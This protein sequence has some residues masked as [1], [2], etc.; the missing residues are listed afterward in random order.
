MNDNKSG[1]QSPVQGQDLTQEQKEKATVNLILEHEKMTTLAN[2][3][4]DEL[5]SAREEIA[6]LRN[7]QQVKILECDQLRFELKELRKRYHALQAQGD[8]GGVSGFLHNLVKE[9]DLNQGEHMV[10]LFSKESDLG[11]AA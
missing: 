3:L 11:R 1:T 5:S 9:M 8:E 6:L 10:A 4:S 2:H 7:A